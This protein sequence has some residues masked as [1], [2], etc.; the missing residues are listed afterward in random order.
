LKRNV[1]SIIR[2]EGVWHGVRFS[3]NKHEVS[4]LEIHQ[5]DTFDEIRDVLKSSDFGVSMD[6]STGYM[7]HLNF[8]FTGKKKIGLVINNELEDVLPFGVEGVEV[9]FQE[10]G[11]GDVLSVA[12]P[13]DALDGFKGNQDIN[14]ITLNALAVLY[15]L[16]WFN[17]LSMPDYAFF[18]IDGNT[19]SIM[20]FQ[21]NKLKYLRQFFYSPESDSLNQAIEELLSHKELAVSTYCL[22]GSDKDVQTQKERIEKKSNIRLDTPSLKTYLK[23]DDCPE[24]LWAGIGAALLSANPKHEINL[25][26]G[27]YRVFSSLNKKSILL[28]GGGIAALS[29][30]IMSIFYLNYYM[31]ERVYKYL[32]SEQ[33]RLYRLVFPNAAPVTDVGKFFEDRVKSIDQQLHGAGINVAMAPLQVL[34]GISSSLDNQI[35]VKLNEFVCDEKEFAISGTTISFGVVEKIQSNLGNV[36][37]IKSV[38]IQSVDIANGNQ[39][40]FKIRGKL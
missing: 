26:R 33:V 39:I 8:P 23:H 38:E 25:L 9:D 36:K 32:T 18:N 20:V 1:S 29:L 30:A 17:I 34:A 16:K 37:D 22:I 27:P 7:V 10:I 21:K 28:A 6:T 14:I 31:K 24:W 3:I 19:A 40:R 11:R 15:A 4:D 2:H 35:D 12:V 13:K 5:K